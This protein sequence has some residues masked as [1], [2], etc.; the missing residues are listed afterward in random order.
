MVGIV[1]Y[2]ASSAV[3]IMLGMEQASLAAS[4]TLVSCIGVPAL[5]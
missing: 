3:Q 4:C 5:S 1:I 2:V